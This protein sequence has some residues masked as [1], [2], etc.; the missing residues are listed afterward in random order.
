[1]KRMRSLIWSR[2]YGWAWILH[3]I[4]FGS[5]L[6]LFSQLHKVDR[7]VSREAV[8][9]HVEHVADVLAAAM[10]VDS[11]YGRFQETAEKL[12]RDSLSRRIL[13]LT[14]KT[15]SGDTIVSVGDPPESGENRSHVLSR[16][17]RVHTPSKIAGPDTV[18]LTLEI[19]V[20]DRDTGLVILRRTSIFAMLVCLIVYVWFRESWLARKRYLQQT[21]G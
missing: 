6:A 9:E 10:H 7:K 12:M 4:V 17:L 8:D 3:A 15:D 18:T 13:Q 19:T 20:D 14:L 2:H 11:T 5:L 1:M 21:R 16:T